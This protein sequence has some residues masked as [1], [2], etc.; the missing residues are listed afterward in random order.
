MLKTCR[1]FAILLLL[2]LIIIGC[3]NPPDPIVNATVTPKHKFPSTPT[4]TPTFIP[5]PSY[6]PYRYTPAPTPPP[7]CG[8][9]GI[10]DCDETPTPTPCNP[11]YVYNDL[12]NEGQS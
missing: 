1:I 8:F 4:A 3:S 9:L 2:P 12:V 10:F 7:T 6:T 5:I 11:S